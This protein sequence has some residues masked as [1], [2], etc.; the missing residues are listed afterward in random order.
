[1]ESYCKSTCIVGSPQKHLVDHKKIIAEKYLRSEL[2]FGLR[3]PKSGTSNLP[4]LFSN[5]QPMMAAD[6][7]TYDSAT[8]AL[9]RQ[10]R[11]LALLP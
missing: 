3:D 5:F 6:P 9:D 1:M 7:L 2:Y 10:A 4:P 11:I 8:V